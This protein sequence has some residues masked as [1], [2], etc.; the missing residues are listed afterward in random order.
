MF[1]TLV[2]RV[3]KINMELSSITRIVVTE[4]WIIKT[5]LLTLYIANQSDAS[6]EVYRSYKQPILWAN[7]W[8]VQYL[9]IGIKSIRA[10]TTPFTIQINSADF[11]ELQ[12][13]IIRPILILPG[14]RFYK[15]QL[16][17]FVDAFKH[18]VEQNA[19]FRTNEVS[20]C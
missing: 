16:E 7:S 10:G 4:S 11:K 13:R 6:L 14:V 3:D 17:R 1:S 5:S 12:D 15:T 18:E 9:G 20:I 19:R 2:L 8:E